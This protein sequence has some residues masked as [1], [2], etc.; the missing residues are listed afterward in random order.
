MFTGGG[1]FCRAGSVLWQIQPQCRRLSLG[2]LRHRVIQT[3]GYLVDLAIEELMS[4][5]GT[6]LGD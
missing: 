3:L 2:C 5:V 6:I 4:S 1:G